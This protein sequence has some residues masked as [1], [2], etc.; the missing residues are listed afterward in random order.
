MRVWTQSTG[1]GR[2]QQLGQ[3]FL[4]RDCY[5][6]SAPVFDLQRCFSLE[7]AQYFLSHLACARPI[8]PAAR[9]ERANAVRRG[10]NFV[11]KSQYSAGGKILTETFMSKFK[12]PM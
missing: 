9:H 11:S 5:F 3:T 1:D 6:R 12:S 10:A 4:D 7:E 8:H 2:N